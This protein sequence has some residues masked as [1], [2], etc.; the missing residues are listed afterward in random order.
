MILTK[1]KQTIV[2]NDEVQIAAYKH[3]GWTEQQPKKETK[4][5]KK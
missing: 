1:G 4:T 5:D 2:L 3:C